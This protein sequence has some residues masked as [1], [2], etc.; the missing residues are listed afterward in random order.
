MEIDEHSIEEISANARKSDLLIK[1][2]KVLFVL[3]AYLSVKSMWLHGADT[4]FLTLVQ[5]MTE[6]KV[7]ELVVWV[8]FA[9]IWVNYIDV[10]EEY[11]SSSM[12]TNEERIVRNDNGEIEVYCVARTAALPEFGQ[13][14]HRYFRAR[15]YLFFTGL[16]ALVTLLFSF[17]IIG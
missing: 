15:L 2:I 10:K 3:I 14:K 7:Y 11:Q 5:T 9:V 6:L 12:S 17:E 16:L 8:S 1:A 4:S 13:R